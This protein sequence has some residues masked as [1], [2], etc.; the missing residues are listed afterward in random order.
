[1]HHGSEPSRVHVDI[2]KLF[3]GLMFGV[4]DSGNFRIGK[5]GLSDEFMVDGPVHPSKQGIGQSVTFHQ[6]DGGQGDAIGNVAD[7]I[8]ALDIGPGIFIDMDET[9]FCLDARRFQVQGVQLSLSARRH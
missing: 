1:M 4:P 5:D 7:R 8:N 3:H 9:S 2:L 6:G